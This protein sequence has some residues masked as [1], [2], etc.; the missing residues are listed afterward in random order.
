LRASH[1]L[2][3]RP[4]AIEQEGPGFRPPVR[5]VS[6]SRAVHRQ[7]PARDAQPESRSPLT[8]NTVFHDR[9]PE[10]RADRPVLVRLLWIE[11]LTGVAFLFDC[12]DPKPFPVQLRY[13]E[14][15]ALIEAEDLV[16]LRDDPYC[17]TPRAEKDLSE[18]EKRIRNERYA[19]IREMVE[20]R[21]R[22]DLFPEERGRMISAAV[23]LHRKPYST[24][25]A[26]L[27]RFWR[28]GQ[29]QGALV[30]SFENCGHRGRP[31]PAGAAKRGRPKIAVPGQP[32]PEPGIN[33]TPKLRALIRKCAKP[34]LKKY[35]VQIAFDKLT[36][37]HFS[38][39]AWDPQK[40]E[41]IRV[42][43]PAHLRPTPGQFRYHTWDLRD[44]AAELE[45]DAGRSDFNMNHRPILDSASD[46]ALFPGHVYQVDAAD[47]K[48]HL[49][50]RLK[51]HEGQVIGKATIY[52][53]VD[54]YSRM[55]V[56][57]YVTLGAPSWEGAM[58][59]LANAFTR[60]VEFCAVYGIKISD[61]DWPCYYL[62]DELVDDRGCEWMQNVFEIVRKAFRI[63]RSLLPARRADAKA[64]VERKIGVVNAEAKKR[65][66]GA[67]KH[68]S[69]ERDLRR[70]ATYTVDL[71][72]RAV[73]EIV[74]FYNNEKRSKDL[75]PL[76]WRSN[77]GRDCRPRDA[78]LY[79][80]ENV[81]GRP[82]EERDET[83]MK[84]KL[85]P[86][87][88]LRETGQ[89]LQLSKP[90]GG[91]TAPLL[92]TSPKAEE[93]HWFLRGSGR[94]ARTH[95]A[96]LDRRDVRHC[97]RII[98]GGRSFEVCTLTPR[99]Q[100]QFGMDRPLSLE[101][102]Q[103]FYARRIYGNNRAA[104]EDQRKRARLT[105][106][107]AAIDKE[108]EEERR[109]LTAA[110]G[111]RPIIDNIRE[112]RGA[113]REDERV[114]TAWTARLA[115]NLNPNGNSGAESTQSPSESSESTVSVNGSDHLNTTPES[116]TDL[117][118]LLTVFKEHGHETDEEDEE[119][120]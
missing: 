23:A 6:T 81:G 13:S 40:K 102:V 10:Q 107:L 63:E 15:I 14:L 87:V 65:P 50:S 88:K 85:L 77:D 9:R 11:P 114:R 53:V 39:K 30:P 62:C 19:V 61:E 60:K 71:I 111:G 42:R 54:V 68:K 5:H 28:H 51:P 82:R 79:G 36:D 4:A 109:R 38:T 69:G 33:I 27:R 84:L 12:G 64:Y 113:S 55:I 17:S 91:R 48:V 73:I 115:D 32:T 18:A 66:G 106:T 101:E 25:L 7:R 92:Y 16:P 45:R 83:R 96:C 26:A 56:G 120:D 34:L 103:D 75:R 100:K 37:K 44:P 119:E 21:K 67:R 99:H 24:V 31:K 58:Q 20:D 46:E 49:I 8:V 97:F 1:M 105:A 72:T 80:M 41:P 29:V 76:G 93:G 94:A 95:E 59:A 43:W 117:E 57:I 104:T 35:G 52:L 112:A 110:N 89:G 47:L 118:L 116:Q 108:A 78:W 90:P 86:R 74:L 22:P 70:N 3:S 98:D 2:R